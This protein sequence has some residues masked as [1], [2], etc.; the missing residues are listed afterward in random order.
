MSMLSLISPRKRFNIIIAADSYKD[1]HY[2]MIPENV[3][4]T[5][6]YIE[7]RGGLFKRVMVAGF[8]MFGKMFLTTPIDMGDIDEAEDFSTRQNG[9]FN[10]EGWEH[11]LNEYQGFLPLEIRALPEGTILP[12]S[13]PIMTIKLIKND[14]KLAWLPGYMETLI[15]RYIWTAC[16]IATNTYYIKNI[17]KP[18]VNLTV[19]DELFNIVMGFMVNDFGARGVY[20]P[21]YTGLG[22]LF[23][24]IGS[25]NKE[26]VYAVNHAYNCD[27][28]AFSIAASEHS[29]MTIKGREGEFDMIERIIEKFGPQGKMFAMVLDSYDLDNALK[30]GIC[31]K[32]KDRIIKYGELGAKVICRPDSGVPEEILPYV[33][34]TLMNGFGYTTNKKGYDCLPPYVGAIQGDGIERETIAPIMKACTEQKISAQNYCFGSGGGLLQQFNRDTM[35]FAM[36]NSATCD[37]NGW[38]GVKKD[39]ATAAW[40]ASKA[41]LVGAYKEEG[42]N[43]IFFM[44]QTDYNILPEGKKT[45]I[46]DAMITVYKGYGELLV[47]ESLDV[48][49]NRI[50][51]YQG[52][53]Y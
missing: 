42:D 1:S 48:I 4:N 39:P 10:R 3:E 28:S 19:E 2:L 32:F 6:F 43:D 29:I 36:K 52:E 40:K 47:D 15:Q 17:I 27:M 18:F 49:K 5:N 8:Q 31:G 25:D 13:V 21:I 37:E 9:N 53:L 11:I 41:G 23:S 20:E 16:T 12:V 22:H 7:P 44:T 45:T 46:K 30:N 50:S 35:K 26:A 34:K 33:V 51:S 14:P 24:F 38:Y